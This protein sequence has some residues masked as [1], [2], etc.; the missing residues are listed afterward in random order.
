MKA[1]KPIHYEPHPVS[2]ERKA[3]LIA[4]GVRIIDVQFTSADWP[5]E[6]QTDGNEAGSGK[7][8]IADLRDALTAAGVGYDPK[9]KKVELQALL[10]GVAKNQ[11]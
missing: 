11:S 7:A 10:D 6:D 5:H 3:E 2:P 9:A 1:E 8:T 4:K